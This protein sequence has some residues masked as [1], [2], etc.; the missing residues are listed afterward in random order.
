MWCKYLL[1]MFVFKCLSSVT[2][3]TNVITNSYERF[4]FDFFYTIQMLNFK[5]I[6]LKQTNCLKD[7]VCVFCISNAT[8]NNNQNTSAH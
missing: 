3:V 7:C 8:F 2:Y 6:L 5:N 4:H 1:K